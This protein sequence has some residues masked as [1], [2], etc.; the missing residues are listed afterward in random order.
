MRYTVGTFGELVQ[1]IPAISGNEELKVEIANSSNRSTMNVG[2]RPPI[3]LCEH[4]NATNVV[5][6]LASPRVRRQRSP[7]EKLEMLESVSSKKSPLK[8]DVPSLNN[9]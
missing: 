3:S 9:L 6:F 1:R 2:L 5:T 8:K 4:F 7:N